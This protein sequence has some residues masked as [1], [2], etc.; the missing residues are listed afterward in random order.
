M[1]TNQLADSRFDQLQN[2][3]E[4]LKENSVNQQDRVMEVI[5]KGTEAMT[6]TMNQ[7]FSLAATKV[8]LERLAF[9]SEEGFEKVNGLLEREYYECSIIDAKVAKLQELVKNT[10]VSRSA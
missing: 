1:E 4:S 2:A 10:Y 3:I 9:T 8:S 6:H 5:K 7:Q